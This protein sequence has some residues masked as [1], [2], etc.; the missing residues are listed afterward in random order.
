VITPTQR[1]ALGTSYR[2]FLD[3]QAQAADGGSLRAGVDWTFTTVPYPSVLGVTPS[4]TQNR[5]DGYLS[6]RFA[7]PM[8]ISSLKDKI[9][10]NPAPQKTVEWWYNEWDLSY[11]AFVLEPS[12]NYE[13]RLL[14][15]MEDI[16]GN[17][18]LEETVRT[19]TTAPYEPSAR[20][21][22]P[23]ETVMVRAN[24]PATHRLFVSH[25]NVQDITLQLYRLTPEKF[26]S[27]N[28]GEPF[29][30]Q[31]EF[32][33]SQADQVWQ[34][35]ETSTGR[36]NQRVLKGYNPVMPD[37]SPLEPGFYFLTLTAGGV[38]Q[39]GPYLDTRVLAV[40]S[41]NLTMKSNSEE[42]LFWLTDLETGAPLSG[43]SV[44]LYDRKFTV[45]QSGSTGT[46]GLLQ[47]KTCLL[48]RSRMIPALP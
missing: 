20:L 8:K 13:I 45:L 48:R 15:G 30:S 25:R 6:I 36:L 11:N 43:V 38:T 12:T 18:I 46:D 44:N 39:Y 37:G 4:S 33:P 5:Y 21:Q 10:I 28:G 23:Y 3:Q 41:A 16:Y 40:V 7:S 35:H 31:W 1:L 9:I 17:R 34:M 19:F 14:P 2:L 26:V 24:A 42:T 27:L 22:L 32:R 29:T 47:V